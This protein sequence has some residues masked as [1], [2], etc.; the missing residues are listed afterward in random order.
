MFVRV[1]TIN[2]FAGLLLG[3]SVYSFSP[4]YDSRWGGPAVKTVDQWAEA[5]FGDF[6][7]ASIF[8]FIVSILAFPFAWGMLRTEI[9]DK[10][11]VVTRAFYSVMVLYGIAVSGSVIASIQLLIKMYRNL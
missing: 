10:R 6:L 2:V 4:S 9:V 7:A 11:E 3:L 8:A 5:A 1:V